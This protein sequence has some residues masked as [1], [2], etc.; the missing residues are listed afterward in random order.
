VCE[1]YQVWARHAEDDIL[2]PRDIYQDLDVACE[3]ADE[4][5]KQGFETAVVRE[6]IGGRDVYRVGK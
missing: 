1:S 4:L 3:F 6:V 5:V 2:M